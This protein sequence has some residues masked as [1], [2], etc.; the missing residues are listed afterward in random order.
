MSVAIAYAPP[1][2][3]V[4]K[5]RRRLTQWRA[6]RPAKLSFAAPVLSVCFDDFPVS[7]AVNGA[8]ILEKHSARGTFYA[9]TGIM[10]S[11]S[12]S[13]RVFMP[14]DA[15]RLAADGHEVGCHT[16]SH[17][18]CARR[19]ESDTLD[20][21]AENYDAIARIGCRE[22]ARTLAYPYGE[23]TLR[24]KR[25]LPAQFSCARGVLPGL[26]VGAV[27]LAQLRAYPL[28]GRGAMKRAHAALARAT[29][30]NAWMI[31]FTHDLSN[32]PSPYG[33][34]ADDLDA[35]LTAA[36]AAG[37]EILPVAQALERRLS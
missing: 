24:L 29:A 15:R 36:R 35:L 33:T 18:D 3:P 12:P 19:S 26:N 21:L 37:V 34:R 9:A 16:S 5:A 31:C 17:E 7:A 25:A 20:D 14:T 11:M 10:G 23:T 8:A 4:S 1:R 28:F 30:S 2:D 32:K 13:G 27:D 22:P 6:A